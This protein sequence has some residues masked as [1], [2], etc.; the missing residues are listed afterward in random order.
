M[1]NV[2]VELFAPY[3]CRV[4]IE[5]SLNASVQG[6]IESI[7]FGNRQILIVCDSNTQAAFSRKNIL[8]LNSRML[9]LE[10]IPHAD[11][12][13]V[14]KVRAQKAEAL[15]AIGGGTINDICKYASFLDGI[16][17]AV[18]PTAPSMNGYFSASASITRN[19]HKFSLPAHLPKG[20]FCDLGILASAPHRL[21]RSGLGDSLCRPTAQAD[22]LLS[23]LL[24]KTA[25]NAQIFDLLVPY[26][27]ELFSHSDK[28]V[29]GDIRV[30]EL[31]MKTLLI[32]G[33]GMV[34]AGGSYP[35]SQGEHLIA[36]TM[37]MKYGEKLPK[38]YH[39]EQIGICTLRM[40]DLQQQILS[41]E[42]KLKAIQ[43]PEKLIATYFGSGPAV[44]SVQ[45]A[46]RS[47]QYLYAQYDAINQR[48][49]LEGT[50]VRDAI[51]AVSLPKDFLHHV[52]LQ[53]GAPVKTQ[54]IGWQETALQE[55]TKHAKFIRN[56]F[57]FLEFISH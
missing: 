18:F 13:T 57:T 53:A 50:I 44:S 27:H 28:L 14:E 54:D 26:E 51:H 16:D 15:I 4:V 31:L 23:H 30:I 43:D 38:S 33:L 29:P 55:A 36:H 45:E 19:G 42:M 49:A 22:W 41:G 46:Y 7:G 9:M 56:R 32:S 6:L 34:L 5:P 20:I 17:Y 40:A 24:W 47:K 25:Y 35:A 11:S 8:A 3:Q 39:G 52:L 12:E 37:E 1:V 48:L 10:G 21:I 2:F